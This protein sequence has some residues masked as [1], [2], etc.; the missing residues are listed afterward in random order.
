MTMKKNNYWQKRE[1]EHALNFR[2]TDLERQ[3][4]IERMYRQAIDNIE[5]EIHRLYSRYASSQGLNMQDAIQQVSK[6]DMDY[7]SRKAERYVRERNFSEQANR[8]MK[9]YNVTMQIN[10]LEYLKELMR[11]EIVALYDL[12][13]HYFLSK[14][15]QDAL[16]EYKRQMAITGNMVPLDK[17]DI[18]SIVNQSFKG[19]TFSER[20]WGFQQKELINV[21][22][23]ELIRGVSQGINPR[24][25]ARNLRQVIQSD[26]KNSERL[27]RTESSRV[28]TE[29]QRDM[30]KR[31]GYDM[32]E[33]IAEPTA[34]EVCAELDGQVFLVDEMEI[35]VNAAPIHPNCRCSTSAHFKDE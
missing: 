29:V 3:R 23:K 31:N 28:M 24:E 6:S 35:G 1:R 34:C 15:N 12:E 26:V 2:Q 27:L 19:A 11:L 10:R 22:E 32:Y 18:H 14:L 7:L 20:I 30:H 25:L 17:L 13:Q 9:R 21:L 5:N 16:E 4:D 8:E 33:F